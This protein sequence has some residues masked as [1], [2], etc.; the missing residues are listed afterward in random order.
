MMKTKKSWWLQEDN[1]SI[2][3]LNQY[4]NNPIH[5][6][7]IVVLVF[8]ELDLEDEF[9]VLTYPDVAAHSSHSLSQVFFASL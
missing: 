1:M 6:L 8:V 4:D 5:I 9:L 3:F 2:L 7:R